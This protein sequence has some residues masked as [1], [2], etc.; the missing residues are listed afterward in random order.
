M[1]LAAY[2][3]D[4]TCNH[5]HGNNGVTEKIRKAM[6]ESAKQFVYIGFLLKE[7]RDYGY[8]K[9]GGYENVYAYAEYELGFKKSSTKNFIAI[10]ENFGVQRYEYKGIRKESQT[11]S[12]QQEYEKFNYSQLVELLAMSETQRSKAKPDMTVKQLR[13]IKR[14]PESAEIDFETLD[15][16]IEIGQTSGQNNDTYGK[17]IRGKHIKDPD[18]HK[19]YDATWQV[20]AA[21]DRKLKLVIKYYCGKNKEYAI[22]Y[23]KHNEEQWCDIHGNNITVA[24]WM[25]LPEMPD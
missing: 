14:Q 5:L 13:E 21:W 19:W 20:P 3:T 4:L 1:A 11:M 7:V 22:G 18:P 10:A 15:K 17:G 8:Y 23:Y 9:E 25:V 6:Y 2:K 12:L 24:Y 16:A